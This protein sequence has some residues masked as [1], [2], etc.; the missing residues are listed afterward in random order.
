MVIGYVYLYNILFY[1]LLD[2]LR[3]RLRG[4]PRDTSTIFVPMILKEGWTMPGDWPAITRPPTSTSSLL[5][6]L[7]VVLASESHDLWARKWRATLKT[8]VPQP[9]AIR[10]QSLKLSYAHV[11]S[12]KRAMSQWSTIE[13]LDWN[14]VFSNVALYFELISPTEMWDDW[15]S[16]CHSFSFLTAS[17]FLNQVCG[18]NDTRFWQKS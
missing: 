14:V 15:V 1:L 18:C 12:V 3:S 6:W 9:T 11:C 4:W 2:T 17:V 13:I 8:V 7:T 16:L 5:E 10:T